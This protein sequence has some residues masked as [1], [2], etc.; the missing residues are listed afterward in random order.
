MSKS[1]K[2]KPELDEVL[3]GMVVKNF[4]QRIN[5]N[6]VKVVYVRYVEQEPQIKTRVVKA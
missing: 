5:S 3:V 4:E 1:K 2:N 6:G